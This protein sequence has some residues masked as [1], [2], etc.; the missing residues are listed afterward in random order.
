LDWTDYRRRI[1]GEDPVA[2]AE[3]AATA[4]GRVWLVTAAGYRPFGDRCERLR[5]GLTSALGHGRQMVSAG[6]GGGERESLWRWPA[7]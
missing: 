7:A 4:T 1:T 6:S 2:A 3:R 5:A